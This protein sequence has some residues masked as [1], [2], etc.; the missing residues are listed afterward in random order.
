LNEILGWKIGVCIDAE[1]R[2]THFV[3]VLEYAPLAANPHNPTQHP[4]RCPNQGQ[5]DSNGNRI[6]T[7][8]ATYV[9]ASGGC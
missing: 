7:Y 4:Q 2:E 8:R 1:D 6:A 9:T 3:V 5:G